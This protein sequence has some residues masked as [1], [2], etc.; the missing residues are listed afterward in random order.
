MNAQD[1]KVALIRGDC[2]NEWEALLWN[3]L[4]SNFKIT[5]F[6]SKKNLYRVDNIDFPIKKLY[7]TT[8]NF[9]YIIIVS[10]FVGNLFECLI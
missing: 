4:D 9:F 1:I 7:S 8:D 3:K 2:L 10:M 5:A 6:S